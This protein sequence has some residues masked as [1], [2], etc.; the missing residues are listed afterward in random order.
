MVHSQNLPLLGRALY[1][2][3]LQNL[4]SG[5]TNVFIIKKMKIVAFVSSNRKHSINKQFA[6]YVAKK[7]INQI[8]EILDLNEYPLPLFNVDLEVES[9]IILI[10][11][12]KNTK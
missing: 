9:T 7:F 2:A 8:V 6:T 5:G 1:S 4:R 11:Q 10:S 12:S 3:G